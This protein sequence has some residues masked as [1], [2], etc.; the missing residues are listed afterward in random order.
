MVFVYVIGAVLWLLA[1]AIGIGYWFKKHRKHKLK[2][3]AVLHVLWEPVWDRIQSN[4]FVS[5]YRA[6]HERLCPQ[7]HFYNDE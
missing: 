3:K 2:I 5:W 7:L 6:I 1:I 4:I